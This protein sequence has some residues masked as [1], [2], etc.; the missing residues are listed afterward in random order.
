M[1]IYAAMMIRNAVKRSSVADGYSVVI[2]T[3]AK[4]VA[5][6]SV[7]WQQLCSKSL[8]LA[9]KLSGIT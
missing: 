5:G 8:S 1:D 7:S 6:L 9:R 2:E 3:S 4:A